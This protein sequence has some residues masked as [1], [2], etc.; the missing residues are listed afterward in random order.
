MVGIGDAEGEM[1]LRNTDCISPEREPSLFS[2][3]ERVWLNNNWVLVV[4]AMQAALFTRV[5]VNFIADRI[6]VA[7]PD[8]PQNE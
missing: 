7:P 3:I 4:T 2:T 6:V 5:I 8:G 1:L